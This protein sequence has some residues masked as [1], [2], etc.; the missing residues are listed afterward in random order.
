[1][2]ASGINEVSFTGSPTAAREI[3]SSAGKALIPVTLELG[4]KSPNII[5]ADADID[6]PV[7]GALAGIFAAAG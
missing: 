2:I 7:V 1:L 4:G 5:F 3:A 6:K